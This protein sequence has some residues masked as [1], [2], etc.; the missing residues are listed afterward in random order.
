MARRGR[1]SVSGPQWAGGDAAEL[2]VLLVS[3]TD[4]SVGA[5]PVAMS[6]MS[7]VARAK[8]LGRNAQTSLT[9]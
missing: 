5:C 1:A 4:G 2:S 3:G 7:Q 6:T 9:A 8:S